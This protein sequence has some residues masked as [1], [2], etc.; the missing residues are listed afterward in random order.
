MDSRRLPKFSG[1]A[2]CKRSA[3]FELKL[4][5]G[6]PV[7]KPLCLEELNIVDEIDNRLPCDAVKYQ[8]TN[9]VVAEHVLILEGRKTMKRARARNIQ[10]FVLDELSAGECASGALVRSDGHILTSVVAYCR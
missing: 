2:S 5:A 7:E 9:C 6:P 8:L 4:H 1:R 3:N 10:V